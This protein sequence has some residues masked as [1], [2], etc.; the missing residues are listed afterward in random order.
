MARR[1]TARLAAMSDPAQNKWFRCAWVLAP[2]L[3][4]KRRPAATGTAN[5]ERQLSTA[6]HAA[7]LAKSQEMRAAEALFAL[8]GAA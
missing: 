5:F 3:N 7:E 1:E 6:M 4:R 2:P 8:C